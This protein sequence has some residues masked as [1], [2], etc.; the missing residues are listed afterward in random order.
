MSVAELKVA[1]DDAVAPCPRRGGP[2]LYKG[3][4]S[5]NPA[6]RPKGSPNKRSIAVRSGIMRVFEKLGGVDA[7]VEWVREN[8]RNEFAFYTAIITKLLERAS[9]ADQ[10]GG[11]ILTPIEQIII[12]APKDPLNPGPPPSPEDVGLRVNDL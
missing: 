2:N 12:Q 5:F 7:M 6:G 4:P 10:A 8:K 11:S 3:M 9:L 1:D